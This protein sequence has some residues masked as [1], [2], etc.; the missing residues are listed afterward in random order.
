MGCRQSVPDVLACCVP[1]SVHELE[2]ELESVARER[3]ECKAQCEAAERQLKAVARIASE[4]AM[5]TPSFPR[6]QS[7]MGHSSA[8]ASQQSGGSLWRR[9]RDGRSPSTGGSPARQPSFDD[10]AGVTVELE[11]SEPVDVYGQWLESC[12]LPT[13]LHSDTAIANVKDVVQQKDAA[14]LSK[15]K[16]DEE[17]TEAIRARDAAT[18]AAVKAKAAKMAATLRLIAA[19]ANNEGAHELA[20]KAVREAEEERDKAAKAIEECDE[21]IKR[22]EAG[23][24][25][26]YRAKK[27][28]EEERNRAVKDKIVAQVERDRVMQGQK[29]QIEAALAQRDEAIEAKEAAEEA[30]KA[31]RAKPPPPPTVEYAEKIVYKFPKYKGREAVGLF[32]SRDGSVNDGKPL[33]KDADGS[34]EGEEVELF[35]ALE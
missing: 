30:L 6:A 34:Q 15:A 21:A 25:E 14:L 12:A 17:K 18:A 29:A 26:A 27:V 28:A 33:Y 32:A 16:A 4:D 35:F 13:L 11:Q 31:E 24:R 9:F 20:R 22:I 3:D 1:N 8:G 7:R 5:S 10:A 23:A 2:H 19:S